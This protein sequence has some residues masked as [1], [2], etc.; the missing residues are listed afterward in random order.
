MQAELR[1][2]YKKAE[3]EIG[4]DVM[5]W[6]T[7]AGWIEDVFAELTEEERK[8]I[9]E[10]LRNIQT[11]DLSHSDSF[12]K[13]CKGEYR[14]LKPAI[15]MIAIDIWL[16][17]KDKRWSQLTARQLN[18]FKDYSKVATGLDNYLNENPSCSPGFNPNIL[19]GEY[20]GGRCIESRDPVQANSLSIKG[21]ENP[22]IF[23]VD[24]KEYQI[25]ENS[26]LD[27]PDETFAS[28]YKEVLSGWIVLS[29]EDN[30]ICFLKNVV[31]GENH[32]YHLIAF[33]ETVL[34]G[35]KADCLLFLDRQIPSEID[36]LDNPEDCISFLTDWVKENE[37]NLIWY[38]RNEESC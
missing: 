16:T 19:S 30:L 14:K 31:T 3:N 15:K 23:S 17:E 12:R 7:L 29:P 4:K 36:E 27:D 2:V 33:N 10:P 35:A 24:V 26:D 6:P 13:F 28:N 1:A 8:W 38:E 25:A 37:G 9:K 32:I 34:D 22:R 5:S 11:V 20:S 21:S 18:G